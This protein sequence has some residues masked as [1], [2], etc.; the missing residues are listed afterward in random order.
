MNLFVSKGFML[1]S[2]KM[3]PR[4]FDLDF[5]LLSDS[6]LT[7]LAVLALFFLL[8]Y[9]LFNPAREFLKKRQDKIKDELEDA[10][11]NQD[12]ALA[13]KQEYELKLREINKEAEA[14][15]SDTRKKAMDNEASIVAKAKEEAARIIAR[16]NT[17]AE[18]EKKKIMD[19]V[20]KEM[21]SVASVM[22]QKVIGTAMKESIQDNLVTDTLK[23]IGD[24]TWLS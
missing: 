15:L 4:L 5:Q 9:L 11:T 20:K 19:D 13:L 12:Q 7:L 18:L 2:A 6:I 8:S 14:I 23:E 3:E 10:K 21:I 24:G 16:A 17:E 22:A 1:A